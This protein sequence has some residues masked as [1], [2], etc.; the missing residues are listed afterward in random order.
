MFIKSPFSSSP[1]LDPTDQTNF[2]IQVVNEA[3]DQGIQSIQPKNIV[4]N[5]I[6]RT[7]DFLFISDN[8][9]SIVNKRL[10]IAGAGKA[11]FDIAKYLIPILGHNYVSGIINIP[12]TYYD[13]NPDL[14]D[15]IIEKTSHPVPD[16][17]TFSSSQKQLDF[18]GS[19]TENDI[20]FVI[21]S[22]GASSLFEVHTKHLTDNDVI[23][24]YKQLLV[25]GLPIHEINTV[26]KHLSQVKGGKLL[27]K[28][29]AQIIAL[30]LSDVPG[31]D[32]SAIGSGPTVEDSATFQDCINIL[33]KRNLLDSIPI[34]VKEF[35]E[36]GVATEQ[37]NENSF[38]HSHNNAQNFLLS[39]NMTIL[40]TMK[41]VI[42]TNGIPIEICSS[43]FTGEAINIG[44][45]LIKYLQFPY[46]GVPICLLFGG[47]SVV[48]I[49]PADLKDDSEG[50]RNQELILSSLFHYLNLQALDKF[51]LASIGT[52]GIDGKSE[53]SGAWYAS[54]TIIQQ[55]NIDRPVIKKFL[56]DHNSSNC[57]PPS[58][59]IKTGP[60]GSNVGDI[61]VL[62][63]Y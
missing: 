2:Y 59:Y 20:V 28:T 42:Q 23:E 10:Y 18:L 58:F 30:L 35:I 17:A 51:L 19:L 13:Q 63:R 38:V 22:G 52:D 54:E 47:E 9:I 40:Q 26:R 46:T 48:T 36:T 61:I 43:S 55:N 50:G 4:K 44:E 31:N 39:S 11:T 45:F 33:L 6:H 60:T 62:L 1:K 56:K 16:T 5:T 29:K 32:I 21:I 49:N 34:T 37:K 25:S 7:N 41:E 3:L 8:Q 53:N 24:T 14:P 12:K 27:T 15:T 57:L